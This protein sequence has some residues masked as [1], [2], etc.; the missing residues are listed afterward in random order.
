MSALELRRERPIA[1]KIP[2]KNFGEQVV[3]QQLLT[4]LDLIGAFV[5]V[6][7]PVIVIIYADTADIPVIKSALEA[8]AAFHN[9]EINTEILD[10]RP[11]DD[12]MDFKARLVTNAA[13]PWSRG[14][15]RA[16]VV[17]PLDYS[18][19]DAVEK[20]SAASV[21]VMRPVHEELERAAQ[22]FYGE[23]YI[24]RARLDELKGYSPSDLAAACPR[25]RSLDDAID[26]L[27]ALTVNRARSNSLSENTGPAIED[28]S[29]YGEASKW[30]AELK[31]DLVDY[32]E[33]RIPWDDVDRGILLSGAPG[34][35]KTTFAAALARSCG[36]PLVTGSVAR[37]Q[38][39]G[40]LGDLL[41]AMRAAFKE[42]IEKAPCILLIDEIDSIGSRNQRHGDND[43]YV[44]E[45]INGLLE[46]LD[47]AEKR[48]GVIVVGTT[49]FAESIDAGILRPGR[50]DR[51]IQIP[52]PDAVARE[53]ILR[54][55]LKEH[56][57]DVD[58][59]PVIEQ[60]DGYSGADLEQIARGARR[61][62]RRA[63]RD[64]L[65][66][67]LISQLPPII[68]TSDE[69]LRRIAIHELGH[70]VVAL[71]GKIGEISEIKVSR[72]STSKSVSAGHVDLKLH[73]VRLSTVDMYLAKIRMWLAG[74]AAEEVFFGSRSDGSGGIAG[75]DLHQATLHA[76]AVH[77]SLGFT[78]VAQISDL[79][80]KSLMR[81]HYGFSDVRRRVHETLDK[82]LS[83]AKA[84]V[85]RH[86]REIEI[87][88]SEL[89]HKGRL[90]GKEVHLALDCGPA[91]LRMEARA[92][93]H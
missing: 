84:I 16:F 63:R 55:H 23:I 93:V 72:Y 78:D 88:A 26:M 59:T 86:R 36:I 81:A 34:T 11:Y 91:V 44:R 32:A 75:S 87:L 70:A 58:L 62:A 9:S 90:D 40:H 19:P 12:D 42:A 53:G 41:K 69:E 46:C 85:K 15:A 79:S 13:G 28:L 30:A 52:L 80:E 22:Y 47:G 10:W 21:Y 66:D 89:V 73:P 17:V 18:V 4:D 77:T 38:A 3:Y 33:K 92:Y 35:G 14:E 45:A 49:N 37:W 27:N 67:D 6:E 82:C 74:M 65:L 8:A 5:D 20:L 64:M 7:N 2:F 24:P 56:L 51:H 39:N 1:P 57:T 76:I 71:Y 29:G 50:L 54:F 60:T 68:R 43:Q 61:V 83:E 48:E 25:D 31:Q